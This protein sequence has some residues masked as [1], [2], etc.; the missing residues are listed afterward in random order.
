MFKTNDRVVVKWNKSYRP[1]IFLSYSKD[2]ADIANVRFVSEKFIRRVLL[3]T[4]I[5]E[6]VYLS[7]LFEAMSELGQLDE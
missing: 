2:F 4:I 1:A 7:P 6:D 3:K 5:P